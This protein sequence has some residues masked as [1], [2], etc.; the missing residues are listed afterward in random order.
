MY[1]G[2]NPNAVFP[3]LYPIHDN[4]VILTGS[5]G[6]WLCKIHYGDRILYLLA[7]LELIGCLISMRYWVAQGD[8]TFTSMSYWVAKG[9]RTFVSMRYWVTSS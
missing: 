1:N 4:T 2:L 3:I 6:F 8:R 9:D 5:V 7:L